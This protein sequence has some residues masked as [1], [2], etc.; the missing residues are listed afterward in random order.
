MSI[1][2]F[3]VRTDNSD[4]ADVLSE[5]QD[6]VILEEADRFECRLPVDGE[7]LGAAFDAGGEAGVDIRILEQ[8]EAELEAQNSRDGLVDNVLEI[9]LPRLRALPSVTVTAVLECFGNPL[10]PT[11]PVR[12]AANVRWRGVPV[13]A[14]KPPTAERA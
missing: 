3:C 13:P 7:V 12:R 4:V 10:E 5:R 14:T 2:D 1:S 8:T 11:V 9:G 6:T